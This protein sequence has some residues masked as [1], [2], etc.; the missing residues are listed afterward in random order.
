PP[1]NDAIARPFAE[2][3][4]VDGMPVP[5]GGRIRIGYSCSG[6][7]GLGRAQLVY[8]VLKKSQADG[9]Q[10]LKESRWVSLPLVEVA[11]TDKAGPFLLRHGVFQNSGIRDQVPFHA[12]ESRDPMDMGRLEGGGRFDFQTKGI[13]DGEGGVLDLQPGDQ[14]EFYIE[15]FADK[16]PLSARP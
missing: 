1:S 4:E 15:V 13:P 8:R 12:V 7:Y 9:E 3:F 11:S 6:P 2:D 10:Q 5:V 16:S 14:V